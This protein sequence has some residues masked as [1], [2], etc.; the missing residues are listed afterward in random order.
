MYDYEGETSNEATNQ[1]LAASNL[2]YKSFS[3]QISATANPVDVPALVSLPQRWCTGENLAGPEIVY[4]LVPNSVYKYAIYIEGKYQRMLV[5]ILRMQG[6]GNNVGVDE[7][8]NNLEVVK[9]G[10]V[11]DTNYTEV[12]QEVHAALQAKVKE[13]LQL[14]FVENPAEYRK[15][16]S[17]GPLKKKNDSRGVGPDTTAT[18]G[19]GHF[20]QHAHRFPVQ[21]HRHDD[22]A[23]CGTV[24][25]DRLH[26]RLNETRDTYELCRCLESTSL[27]KAESVSLFAQVTHLSV[28]VRGEENATRSDA[29]A[30][31]HVRY[32]ANCLAIRDNVP[33]ASK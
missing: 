32:C 1:S 28:S 16:R 25:C 21:V 9:R 14:P 12:Y 20:C 23:L 13:A 24:R 31:A 10:P 30:G 33:V 19:E 27:P 4:T 3:G 6:Y 29:N 8:D 7:L 22:H 17:V 2:S 26:M 5:G 11:S 15:L 18:A